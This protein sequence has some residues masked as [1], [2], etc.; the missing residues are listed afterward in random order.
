MEENNTQNK[1][2][3][4]QKEDNLNL[5][6]NKQIDKRKP[7]TPE[8][9]S[10]FKLKNEKTDNRYLI[11][12]TNFPKKKKRNEISVDNIFQKKTEKKSSNIQIIDL[13]DGK[14]KVKNVN[15]LKEKKDKEIKDK[16]EKENREKK[17]NNL[18]DK[19]EKELKEK[20]DKENKDKKEKESKDKK[21]KEIK[22]KKDKELKEKKEKEQKEKKEKEQKEKKE[23]PLTTTTAVFSNR[24]PRKISFDNSTTSKSRE[25]KRTNIKIE[26]NKLDTKVS[27][28][29]KKSVKK[30]DK[31]NNKREEKKDHIKNNIKN[32]EVSIELDTNKKSLN[33]SS[34]E[35]MKKDIKKISNKKENINLIKPSKE[36][37]ELNLE[38]PRD[39]SNEKKGISKE[40]NIETI[41]DN[42]LETPVQNNNN[43]KIIKENNLENSEENNLKKEN[44]EDNS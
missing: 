38:T 1:I 12:V 28:E 25:K 21:E 36:T 5:K 41:K 37:I 27:S 16:K 4:I 18:K 33:F 2:K 30:I 23:K 19:K 11:T 29:K 9:Y 15:N 10:Y 14:D 35:K 17:D 13:T 24:I 43:I 40:N 6:Q 44:Q 3:N 8:H 20:K 39:D 22:E 26:G 34:D 32:R 42:Q 31:K 7:T